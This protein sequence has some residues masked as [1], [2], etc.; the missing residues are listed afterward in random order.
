[1]WKFHIRYNVKEEIKNSIYDSRHYW[2][3]DSC[4][5]Q[6]DSL[7]EYFNGKRYF[8]VCSDNETCLNIAILQQE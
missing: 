7:D 1:M 3:C 8:A 6:A 4:K 2:T 5:K